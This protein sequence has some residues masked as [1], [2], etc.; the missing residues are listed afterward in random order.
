MAP[1][2]DGFELVEGLEPNPVEVRLVAGDNGKGV[3]AREQAYA[4]LHVHLFGGQ[5]FLRS[6]EHRRSVA[7]VCC[8]IIRHGVK[9]DAYP[10]GLKDGHAA[11]AP[12]EFGDAPG[13]VFLERADGFKALQ[14]A[15]AEA[16]PA[17]LALEA[18]NDG[19]EREDA[20][21][22][23]VSPDGVLTGGGV[24]AALGYGFTS[25]WLVAVDVSTCFLAGQEG[26]FV[27]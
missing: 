20:V 4:D 22:G 17:N 27:W 15:V 9:G 7:G 8:E 13:E 21:F 12:E 2:L 3:L 23:C 5:R 26:E 24:G 10:V 1:D 19:G 14:D 6:A 11:K 25:L 18:G 16:L